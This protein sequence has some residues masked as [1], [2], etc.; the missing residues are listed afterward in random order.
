MILA[1]VSYSYNNT[2]RSTSAK[3]GGFSFATP[4]AN[5]SIRTNTLDSRDFETG[6]SGWGRGRISAL[7]T[8]QHTANGRGG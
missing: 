7:D 1:Y 3:A 4:A 6:V 8:N 2:S 5:A